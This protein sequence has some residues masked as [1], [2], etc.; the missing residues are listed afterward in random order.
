MSS[1]SGQDLPRNVAASPGLATVWHRYLPP[2]L[3]PSSSTNPYHWS[4]DE[5]ERVTEYLQAVWRAVQTYLPRR[6]VRR[7]QDGLEPGQKWGELAE[8]TFLFADISGF[9]ALADHLSALPDG[10]EK[11]TALINSY[12]TTMLQVVDQSCREIVGSESDADGPVYNLLK[13][14]GDAMLLLFSGPH[15]ARLAVHAASQMQH[16]MDDIVQ[17]AQSLGAASL[18]MHI[19]INSGRFLDAHVGTPR[20]MK[21]V[22]VGHTLSLTAKAEEIAALGQTAIGSATYEAVR[23]WVATQPTIDGFYLLD[24]DP[25]PSAKSLSA[26][27]IL[28]PDPTPPNAL[29]DLIASLDAIVP[30]LLPGLLE[31]IILDPYAPVVWADLKPVTVLFANLLGLD[32]MVESMGSEGVDRVTAILDRYLGAVIEI[33]GRYDGT[34]NKMDLAQEGDKLLILFGAPHTHEDDPQRAVRTALEMQEALRPFTELNTLSGTFSLQLRVG[35]HSGNVFAGN[36][37]SP[38]RKEYTVMG[39][40]VNLAARLVAA[41]EP[42]QIL[43][44]QTTQRRLG[45]AF[46]CQASFPLQVKGKAKAIQVCRVTGFRQEGFSARRAARHGRLIGRQEELS[47]LKDFTGYVLGG[48]GQVVSLVGGAGMGKSRLVDELAVHA[49]S[50]GMRVLHGGCVSYGGAMAY[51]PWIEL[52]RDLLEWTTEDTATSRHEKLQALLTAVDSTLADWVP[53]VAGVLGLA[54]P[55]TPL[56]SALDAKLR[57][58]RFFDI[59]SQVLESQAGELPLLLIFED[60]HWADPISLELLDYVARNL[61]DNPLLLVGIRRPEGSKPQWDDLPHH[62]AIHLKELSEEESRELAESLLRMPSLPPS[63]ETMILERAQGNPFYVEEVVHVLIDQGHLVPEDGEYRLVGDLST[64]EI[65]DTISGVVMSRIDSLDEGNRTVLRV[66]S[67]IG[68]IFLY[69]V[70]HEIYPY[71]IGESTLRQ[72]LGTLERVDLTPLEEPEPNLQY[73]FKH[74]LTQEVAYESLLHARRRELHGQ[75]G[76]YYETTYG[77]VGLEEYY[78]LLALHFGR[79]NHREKALEYEIQA[80]DRARAAYANDAAIR[81]YAA[82]LQLLVEMGQTLTLRWADLQFNLAE[83]Y[84]H[85]GRY[86]EAVESYQHA[87][88]VAGQDWSVEQQ[89]RTLRKIGMAYESQGQYNEALEWLVRARKVAESDSVAAGS[90]QMARILSGMGVVYLRKAEFATGI[91][92]IE[93]ALELLARLPESA[94]RLRDEGWVYNNLGV[95]HWNQG[96]LHQAKT[97]FEQSLRLFEQAG[98]LVGVATLHNNLGYI[99]Y[100]LG[101]IQTAIASCQR[102]LSVCDQIGYLSRKAMASNN[103]GIFFQA[104]GNYRQAIAYYQ[105]SLQIFQKRGELA[106]IASTYDNLG[107]AC[108]QRGEYEKAMEYHHLSLEIKR[109]QEDTLQIANSL[110]NIAAV[111]SDRGYYEEAIAFSEEALEIFEEIGGR[112]Y[113]A[114][115]YSVLGEALLMSGEPMQAHRYAV[116]ALKTAKDTGSQKDQAIAARI[117]GEIEM[118][119]GTNNMKGGASLQTAQDRLRGSVESLEKVGDRF[120]LGKSLRSLGRCLKL[121]GCDAEAASYLAR[122]AQ[123]FQDLGARGE[124]KKAV[125]GETGKSVNW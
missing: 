125:G 73:I 79:S 48:E 117:L 106:G 108:H 93:G 52:L 116:L 59:V 6:A 2:D 112:Q 111:C 105:Q 15:H 46:L 16:A 91:G 35:I 37:G 24:G 107:N 114:E 47:L 31:K 66:A 68:R 123:T 85:V 29:D 8:G 61:G 51:L 1:P 33:V 42:G 71:P 34:L 103:L 26:P 101:D 11:L 78:D 14:G 102:S 81:H 67:V 74:I 57:K 99:A 9:T 21:K 83:V 110:I 56:T 119:H 10:T 70:L 64:I 77:E 82:A 124:L 92:L 12:F 41:A 18:G 27:S 87:M 65:P 75:V 69:Q 90:R 95:T 60:L 30:Y 118:A 72:R 84:V 32:E 54:V 36:V 4:S 94:K 96:N 43:V 89:A 86:E 63:L 3:V 40:T 113:L 98:D 53:V 45:D 88:K 104:S 19:G 20:A 62:Q 121:A 122:A 44:T 80:G 25:V 120:E 38:T 39:D 13:F 23:D 49:E 97:F 7:L 58:E 76:L 100:W 55:D 50:V 22:E 17:E 115:A 5:R 28:S 109:K